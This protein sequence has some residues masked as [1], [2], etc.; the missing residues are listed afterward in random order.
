M[1]F[2]KNQHVSEEL[3]LP[4]WYPIIWE[5]FVY[6][7]SKFWLYLTTYMLSPMIF[8]LSFGFGVGQRL[9]MMMPGGVSYLEFLIPGVVALALFNNGVTSVIIR[10]FYCRLFYYSFEAYQ[11]APL[12]TF[13]IWFGYVLVGMLR[14]L[15]S[16]LIVLGMIFIFIPVLSFNWG[17]ILSMFLVSF[18]FG[19]MG[20][21]IGL[22]LRSFDDHALVSEFIIVPM[23]FLS[24]T[25]IPVERLP[26]V[27]QPIVWLFPL[28]P[29]TQLLRFSFADKGF[30]LEMAS[31]VLGWTLLFFFLGWFKL[32]KLND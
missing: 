14:G 32:T 6:W 26:F 4:S 25:L 10:M 3:A 7:K 1:F 19:A 5:E 29:A 22:Y 23:T 11:L 12:S 30:S 17:F 20:V 18:C 16:G 31:I 13:S 21:L 15:I 28:T 9:K 8:L 2:S 27:L 24:G